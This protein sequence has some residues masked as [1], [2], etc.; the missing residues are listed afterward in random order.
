[1]DF[2]FR[3]TGPYARG[4]SGK[5][6]Q[7]EIHVARSMSHLWPCHRRQDVLCLW[8]RVAG[9]CR[10]AV[11]AAAD[12]GCFT[13]ASF[14]DR[15]S[16]FLSDG[17]GRVARALARACHRAAA[18]RRDRP[19]RR[20]RRPPRQRVVFAADRAGVWFSAGVSDPERNLRVAA[21]GVSV[22]Q[23]IVCRSRC[24]W[25]AAAGLSVAQR[26]FRR[27]SAPG[28]VSVGQRCVCPASLR[29]RP[30]AAFVATGAR[31]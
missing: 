23:R 18:A 30:R 1:M 22:G 16:G 17:R 7:R 4:D 6:G 28:S 9:G 14:Q 11:A 31:Q 10:G 8:L 25:C 2:H 27:C 5:H 12:A 26:C 24:V 20:L 3:Q 21:A 29:K 13:L 19:R 15:I